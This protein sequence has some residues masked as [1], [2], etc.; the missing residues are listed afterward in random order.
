MAGFNNFFRYEDELVA[1]YR[2]FGAGPFAYR[3]VADV[4]SKR[5]MSQLMHRGFLVL[6]ENALNQPRSQ[7]RVNRWRLQPGVVDR[8]RA[9]LKEVDGC[10]APV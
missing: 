7:G 2:R 6:H 8:C 5:T 3:E 10:P 9:V 1:V 4:V